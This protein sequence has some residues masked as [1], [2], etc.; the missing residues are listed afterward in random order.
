MEFSQSLF[1]LLLITSLIGSISCQTTVAPEDGTE[2]PAAGT[3]AAAAA[4]AADGGDAADPCAAVDAAVLECTTKLEEGEADCAKLEVY[5]SCIAKAV[6]DCSDA[7]KTADVQGVAADKSAEYAQTLTC[8]ATEAAKE[9]EKVTTE[10]ITTVPTTTEPPLPACEDPVG[11]AAQVQKCNDVI[12][13]DSLCIQIQKAVDCVEQRVDCSDE[14]LDHEIDKYLES[15]E[16][17][18]TDYKCIITY[19]GKRLEQ[20]RKPESAAQSQ[21]QSGSAPITISL[22]SSFAVIF[23]GRLFS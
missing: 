10:G 17:Y 12:A 1:H 5:N 11:K 15:F 9:E 8:E 4:A 13:Q 23:I 6:E 16:N 20:R 7:T 21:A 14:K 18:A 19:R 2:V 22:I 3:E